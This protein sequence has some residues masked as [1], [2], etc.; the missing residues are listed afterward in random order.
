MGALNS[1]YR[2][3]LW[4]IKN[5]KEGKANLMDFESNQGI[6]IIQ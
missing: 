1:K 5:L 4:I 6:W 3:I 2:K